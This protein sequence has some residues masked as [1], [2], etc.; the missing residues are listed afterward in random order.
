MFVALP[1]GPMFVPLPSELSEKK[2]LEQRMSWNGAG[3]TY[4]VL[5]QLPPGSLLR[6][7]AEVHSGAE[8]PSPK[9]CPGSGYPAGP[10]ADWPA[11]PEQ[12]TQQRGSEA[13]AAAVQ[14][15]EASLGS[16]YPAD[17]KADR[18]KPPS[19]DEHSFAATAVG[20]R[21]EERKS[22]P[23]ATIA[24]E[25]L[26][27]S[28]LQE[29]LGQDLWKLKPPAP[30][31][32]SGVSPT[33]ALENRWWTRSHH[34]LLCPLT[35]FPISLLPYPPFKLRVNPRKPNP[36][37]L[38]DGKCLAMH[39]IVNSQVNACGRDIQASDVNALDEY[40]HR[41]KLGPFRPGR[42]IELMNQV[43]SAKSDGERA[44]VMQEL[45]RFRASARSEMG[46]LRRI[47][48][49]RL[50]QLQHEPTSTKPRCSGQRAPARRRT[51]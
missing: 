39:L 17:L 5:G 7:A 11:A 3:E 32:A 36:Y 6:S 44:L 50:Q 13:A 4:A 31:A 2:T 24:S 35:N 40:I 12:A 26:V 15:S 10:K 14:S 8:R 49:N 47:Q 42:V 9:A 37:K 48:E 23:A 21:Y 1:P 41:C 18:P 38:V 43:T 30:L 27:S 16:G 45:A 19:K 51:N 34:P 22:C 33:S 25:V 20:Q 28:V 29:V 46:K